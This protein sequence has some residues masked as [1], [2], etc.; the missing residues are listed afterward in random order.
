MRRTKFRYPV[1]TLAGSTF[2]NIIALNKSHRVEKGYRAKFFLSSAIAGIFE[3]FNLV[4]R[5][6]YKKRIRNTHAKVPPVFIIGF[7]RSGTTLLHN[8]LC[9]DPDASYVTTFQTVFPNLMLTQSWWLKPLANKFLPAKRPFDNVRWDMDSPQEE[10]FGM[11]NMQPHTI[12]K[13]FLYPDDFDRIIGEELFTGDLS[14][15]E[16]E[17]WKSRYN[18]M[19]S[20]A[21]INTGGRRYIGKNPCHITRISLLRQMYPDAKFIFIHRDPC[22]VIESFYRFIL[23][24]FPGVQLQDVPASFTR[25]KVAALYVKMMNTYFADRDKIPSSDLIEIRMGDF[26]HDEKGVLEKIYRT[27]NLGDFSSLVPAIEKYLT[28]NP[29]PEHEHFEGAPETQVLVRRYASVI[30][31]KLGYKIREIVS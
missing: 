10:D 27:F 13:F 6:A 12:Y 9:Q 16:L 21:M 18:E 22:Q 20:K 1:T 14:T 31:E 26:I 29:V 30:A 28:E 11:M 23:S 25:D 2:K 24:I 8:L 5:I 17:K 3:I 19:I 7:W 15:G 4:E